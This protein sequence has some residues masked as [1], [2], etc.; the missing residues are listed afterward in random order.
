MRLKLTIEY[1]GTRYSG[2]QVQKNARTIQG[3]LESAIREAIGRGRLEVYGAGRTDA[4]VH[5]LAQVAHVDLYFG[6][7]G[8]QMANVRLQTRDPNFH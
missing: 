1:V 8:P 5:A 2:W 4:G 6:Y 7:I 3:E